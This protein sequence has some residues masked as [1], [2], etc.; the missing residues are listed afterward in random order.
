MKHLIL[1]VFFG[2]FF[3]LDLMAQVDTV[4]TYFQLKIYAGNADSVYISHPRYFGLYVKNNCTEE[5]FGTTILTNSGCWKREFNN[6]SPRFW[7]IGGQSPS[8]FIGQVK[9]E[10]DAINSAVVAAHNYGGDTIEIAQMYDIDRSVYLLSGNTYLG[11][12]DS[13]GFRRI[14]TPKTIITQAAAEGAS[15]ISVANNTGF[16][17]LQAINISHDIAFDSLAGFVSYTASV[18]PFL[19]GDTTIF[20]S[21]LSLQKAVSVGDSVSLFFPIMTPLFGDADSIHFKNLVFDGNRDSYTLNYDWRVNVGINFPTSQGVLIEDCRF[22]NSTTENMFIC[23]ATI[24]NCSGRDFNGS[25]LHFSCNTFDRPM[26]VL[27]NDF[28]HLNEVGDSLMEHSEAGMTFSA[29][30]QNLR[31]AYNRLTHLN[32]NGIGIFQNDDKLVEVT[33]NLFETPKEMIAYQAF[34]TQDSTNVIYNNKNPL[35]ADLADEDCFQNTPIWEGD[36][37]CASNSTFANPLKLGDTIKIVFDSLLV[38]NSNENFVKCISPIYNPNFFELVDIQMSTPEL[39]THHIWVFE[40]NN[41]IC[42]G[43]IFDNGHENGSNATG[44]WGYEGC[45]ES[46]KC[47]NLTFKF[48]VTEMPDTTQAVCCPLQ[49]IEILYDGDLGTWEQLPV[50]NNQVVNYSS[51]QLGSPILEGDTTVNVVN[52]NF[53]KQPKIYPNP[54]EDRLFFENENEEN[55]TYKIVNVLGQNVSIGETS[56]NSINVNLLKNGTY[57]L[58]LSNKNNQFKA[59]FTKK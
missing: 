13:C 28:S 59:V 35:A 51:E 10:V 27:Y 17:T 22:Y 54:V 40:E 43:L 15:Q 45:G 46:Q 12:A 34:Y 20:L 31:V 7:E 37:P 57:Y 53:E 48:I 36:L 4:E 3:T 47:T 2:L 6:L 52:L 1:T 5:D 50:C 44:N 42:E 49:A 19:G 18:S 30:V 21:G 16:R 25:A 39:S 14:D 29:K 33:D 38:R 9:E 26:E 11:T 8:I 55:F 41:S 58:I 56:N 23:G 24:R 32:E